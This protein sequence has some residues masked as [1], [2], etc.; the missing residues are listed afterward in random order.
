[1]CRTLKR[2]LELVDFLK[3]HPD[4]LKVQAPFSPLGND[5]SKQFPNIIYQMYNE[6]LYNSECMGSWF[7]LKHALKSKKHQD[8]LYS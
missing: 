7:L 6:L 5:E 2:K 8:A 4:L 1:M 3:S